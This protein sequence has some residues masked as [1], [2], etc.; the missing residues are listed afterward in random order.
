MG[1]RDDKVSVARLIAANRTQ[2]NIPHAVSCRLM[3]VSESWFYKWRARSPTLSELRRRDLDKA[4]LGA[5]GASGSTYGSPRVADE[6]RDDGWAVSTKTVAASMR[7]QELTARPKRRT[8]RPLRRPEAAAATPAD[9]LGRNFA[10][11][12]PNQKWAGD[13]KQIPTAE[14]PVHLAAVVDL[15]SRR[16]VG[17]ALSDHHPTAALAA[18]AIS[19][20]TATRGGDVAGVIFHTDRG[21]QTGAAAFGETCERLG[22]TQSMGRPG[23]A[24][25]N[26]PVESFFATLQKELLHRRRYRTR[27]EARRDIAAWIEGWYNPRRRHRALDSTSPINYEND[28]L[29]RH[30]S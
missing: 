2:L 26:A 4:V 1:Q 30:T 22:I 18:D 28:H 19:M 6:L 12:A 14:G 27:V 10:A 17:F 25:D 11:A 16:L 13:F 20:A 8:R 21:P 15:Y 29:R 5:F 23:S 7:R 9:L 3:G 24:L